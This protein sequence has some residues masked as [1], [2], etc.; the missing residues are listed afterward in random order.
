MILIMQALNIDSEVII[1]DE[2]TSE[3]DSIIERK[4]LNQI[5]KDYKDRI[6]III[7]H[8]KDNIDLFDKKLDF[9]IYKKQRRN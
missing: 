3:L 2:T 8:R 6:F 4:I 9:D 5:K 1:F 7:S